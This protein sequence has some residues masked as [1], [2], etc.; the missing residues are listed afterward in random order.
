MKA[1]YAINARTVTRVWEQPP[2]RYCFGAPDHKY[3]SRYKDKGLPI[4]ELGPS[5][6]YWGSPTIPILI[7]LNRALKGIQKIIIF[8]YRLKGYFGMRN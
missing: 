3:Y 6:H 2:L 1:T 7:D 5:V 8:I 4:T